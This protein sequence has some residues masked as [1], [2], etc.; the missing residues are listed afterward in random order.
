MGYDC[1]LKKTNDYDKYTGYLCRTRPGVAQ[2]ITGA[3]HHFMYIECGG[4]SA[5]LEEIERAMEELRS[6]R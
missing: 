3:L 1:L 5:Y 4:G 2:W 6:H